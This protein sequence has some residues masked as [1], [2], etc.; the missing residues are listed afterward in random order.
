MNHLAAPAISIRNL[1]HL[2]F[3]RRL[4]QELGIARMIGCLAPK[5]PP[6]KVS[7]GE[8]RRHDSERPRLSQQHPV[9]VP[10]ILR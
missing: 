2:W 6:F 5:T 7:Y 3:G 9:H 4:C 8:A 10:A 1:D